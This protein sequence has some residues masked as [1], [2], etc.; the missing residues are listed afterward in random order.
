MFPSM[1]MDSPA[2]I[3]VYLNIYQTSKC[4]FGVAEREYVSQRS[5]RIF[6]KT[7]AGGLFTT[8]HAYN[9]NWTISIYSYR[10]IVIVTTITINSY[11]YSCYSWMCVSVCLLRFP[12]GGWS[13][14]ICQ[15]SY[16]LSYFDFVCVCGTWKRK[17]CWK[18]LDWIND[19]E[20]VK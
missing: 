1:L 14:H 5:L 3:N 8:S 15:I 2:V 19:F 17:I 10:Y 6:D 11:T 16:K 18:M 20:K 9:H 13:I 12:K 7:K 4:T